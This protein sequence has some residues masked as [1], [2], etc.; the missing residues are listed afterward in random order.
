MAESK[1]ADLFFV[2]ASRARYH[3]SPRGG[4]GTASKAMLGAVTLRH[5]AIVFWST[6]SPQH[7][8]Q[9]ALSLLL[10]ASW[11]G[12]RLFDL[13]PVVRKHVYPP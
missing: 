6:S 10:S 2:P 5:A 3:G 1:D 11:V 9:F 7:R 13:L 12:A 8:L 4:S